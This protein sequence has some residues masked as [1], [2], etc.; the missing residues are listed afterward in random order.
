MAEMEIVFLGSGTSHGIPMI[1]CDC[2]VCRS[3]DPRDRRLRTCVALALPPGEPTAGRVIVIDVPP[4]FRLEA[5]ANDL[6]RVD[7]ELFTHG[8]ADHLMGLD[9]LRRY[10]NLMNATIP[11]Y[12][13]AATAA[14]VQRCF[15]YAVG[16]YSHPDR[17]S[18]SLTTLG[19]DGGDG[20]GP[21]AAREI[22]G[23]RVQPVPLVHGR[24]PIL[25]Y[26][27]GSFAYCTDCSEIPDASIALLGGLD[28]LVL[29]ALR[30][31]PHPTHFNLDGALAMIAQLTPRRTLL[32]HIAHEIGHAECTARLP[33]G[34]EI[35]YD[36]LRVRT[37]I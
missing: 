15:G 14:I 31:T 9:D 7:A 18:I 37:E 34:V 17:P 27:I 2:R 4:E 26:R 23:V 12:A 36:G 19:G 29:D 28:L 13:D 11:C 25:G 3:S 10:N 16:P 24:L 21:A 6:R 22:C 5:I 1:G 30:Y 8:H 32:T 20:A 33:K 35:A